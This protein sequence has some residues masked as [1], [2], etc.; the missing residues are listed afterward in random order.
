MKSPIRKR[1]NR[2]YDAVASIDSIYEAYASKKKI[3]Y[4]DMLMFYEILEEAEP[5]TQKRLCEILEVSKTTL[6]S[7]VKRWSDKGC[8]EL[9]Q[10]EL[11][12]K[13]KWIRLTPAGEIFAHALVDPLFA[14]E[15]AAVG[16]ITDD[17]IDQVEGIVFKYAFSLSS[18]IEKMEDM[19]HE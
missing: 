16:R 11:R 5:L 4:L 14:M 19:N 9:T 7:V 18:Q 17:E 13:E 8:I 3:G 12:S 6:N 1:V 15:E 10:S 2:I